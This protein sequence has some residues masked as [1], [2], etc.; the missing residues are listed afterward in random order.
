M[1]IEIFE[2]AAAAYRHLGAIAYLDKTND[3]FEAYQRA[4]KLDPNNKDGWNQLG[5]LYYRKGELV[6][7]EESYL[8]VLELGLVYQTQGDLANKT[9]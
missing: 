2:M 8:K 7:A 1:S 4:T 6:K 9:R 3:A 5:N